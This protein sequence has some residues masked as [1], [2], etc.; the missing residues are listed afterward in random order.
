MS[1][2]D[3]EEGLNVI[4]KRQYL[5]GNEQRNWGVRDAEQC[6]SS[7]VTASFAEL[8]SCGARFLTE[9]TTSDAFLRATRTNL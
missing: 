9:N 3:A 4:R 1:Q 2:T 5:P 6:H 8:F 7:T